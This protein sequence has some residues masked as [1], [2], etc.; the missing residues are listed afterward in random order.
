MQEIVRTIRWAMLMT[1][2]VSGIAAADEE[3]ASA[4]A[5]PVSRPPSYDLTVLIQAPLV[6]ADPEQRESFASFTEALANHSYSEAEVSAKR[7]VELVN[8]VDNDNTLDAA[9]ARA[10]AL[11][12]LAVAQQ[13][14]GS[15]ESARQNY[16]AVLDLIASKDDNLSPALILPLRGLAI[17][18][19]DTGQKHEADQVFDRAAHVSNVNFGPHSLQQLPILSTRMQIYIKDGD[20]ESALDALD[21]ITMLYTRK[22]PKYSEELLPAYYLQAELYGELGFEVEERSALR[23]VLAIKRK[24]YPKND[25][26]LIEPNLKIAEN[27]M[28]AMARDDFRSVTTSDAEKHLKRALWIAENNGD[29]Q[30]EVRKDCLLSIAD[31][32]TLFD[33]KGRA[34]RYYAE[35]W[36]LM[37]SNENYLASRA[38]ALEAPVPLVLPT[39][40]PYAD[41]EYNPNRG[42]LDPDDYLEGEMVMA[43]TVNDRGRTENL[44]LIEANPENFSEME[45]RLHN[46][47]RE[48]VYRPRLADGKASATED[49]RYSLKYF[50]TPTEY[51]ASLEKAA[52]PRSPWQSQKP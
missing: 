1:L 30:W 17:A 33:M 51:Q 10:R 34:R 32:Y 4:P 50:Y 47:V 36:D 8:S 38:A 48:F 41:F 43:F 25:L 12:N 45:R 16:E 40:N 19:M 39:P 3:S 14:M 52:K 35:A 15:H 11:Q 21:R 24:N 20:I 5:E 31:F 37:S 18:H 29:D 23:H 13:Y 9:F 6:D 26:A 7:M 22:Y 46:A 42:E 27:M 28:R 49:L 2:V 44:R